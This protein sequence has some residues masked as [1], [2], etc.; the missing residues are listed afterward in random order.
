MQ[1][2]LINNLRAGRNQRL[3]SSVFEVLREH[4]EVQHVE[5]DHAAVVPE[6]LADLA[7]HEI[8]L[9]IVNGGDGTLQHALSEILA[10]DVFEKVPMIA[11]LRGGRTNMTAM[12]LG[13]H[14]NPLAGLRAVLWAARC[15]RLAERRVQRP[16][17][18]VGFDRGRRT[19]Y[20]MFFGAGMI[21]RAI[22]LV[23]DV[24][25][26]GR[27][28][29]ALGAGLVTLALTAKTIARS[30]DGIVTPDKIEVRLD[31][32]PLERGELR[33]AIASTLQRLFWRLRPFWGEG[34]GGVRFTSIAG[35]ARRF[36]LAAPGV[37]WGRPPALT[38]PANG[39]QSENVSRAELRLSC[40]FTI[41]GE[42]FD[43]RDDEAVVL[44]SDSRV[45]FIRA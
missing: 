3:V 41:D 27:S 39:Y 17:L 37:L 15:G 35:D 5:T 26:T 42:L 34:P 33:I 29:G 18:R 25:P 19:E 12:D 9:L 10:H 2:G 13:A 36:G 7:R 22:Q 8:D 28:Q 6:A 11:P 24:F 16:V 20:G 31:G 45:E 4:P 40:G 23:H 43:P 32:R 38:T 1:V 14:R 21:P 30:R 44:A